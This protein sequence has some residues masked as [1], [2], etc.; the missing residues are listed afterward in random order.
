[1]EYIYHTYWYTLSSS[2]KYQT[3]QIVTIQA[4]QIVI[5][6]KQGIVVYMKHQTYS[7]S[8]INYNKCYVH[9]NNS[10]FASCRTVTLWS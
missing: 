1:M 8:F 4:T 9:I 10:S 2:N 3:L 6:H 5:E 7:I